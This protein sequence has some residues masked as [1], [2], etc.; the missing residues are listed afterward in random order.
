MKLPGTSAPQ[1]RISETPAA[2]KV[3]NFDFCS[4]RHFHLFP[5]CFP[6]D[7]PV[8]FHGHT[9]RIDLQMLK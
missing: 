7:P 4:S 5:V 9:R 3:N 2:D 6:H 8:D 1:I